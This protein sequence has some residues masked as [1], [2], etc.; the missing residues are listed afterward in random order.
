M[1]AN[2]HAKVCIDLETIFFQSNCLHLQYTLRTHQIP[3]YN[4][5]NRARVHECFNL[6]LREKNV[7]R[8]FAQEI[9]RNKS[10]CRTVLYGDFATNGFTLRPFFFHPQ[11]YLP[12]N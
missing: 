10:S 7:N 11:V 6:I 8:A 1:D 3:L 12:L 5:K 4:I 9:R 2:K